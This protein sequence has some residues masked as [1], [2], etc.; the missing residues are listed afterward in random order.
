[1]DPYVYF[2]LYIG[3]IP[4]VINLCVSPSVVSDSLRPHELQPARLLC[5]WDSPGN[6]TGVGCH[7]LLQGIF[8]TQGLNPGLWHCRQIL[9]QLN[10]REALVA[11]AID[12]KV[13]VKERDAVRSKIWSSPLPLHRDCGGKWRYVTTGEALRFGEHASIYLAATDV[14]TTVFYPN[15]QILSRPCGSGGI[16]LGMG[17]K[18]DKQSLHRGE[19]TLN[20]LRA[21]FFW[22]LTWSCLDMLEVLCEGTPG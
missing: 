8:P 9:Y 19:K 21:S 15:M 5:P 6:N 13:K 22:A 14:K 2:K 12:T 11:K 18:P 16:L 17:N 10:H 1:M 3:N 7:F 20:F 4:V